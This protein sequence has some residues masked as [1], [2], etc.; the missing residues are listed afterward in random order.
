MLIKISF[1]EFEVVM[2]EEEAAK[3]MASIPDSENIFEISSVKV[4]TVDEAIGLWENLC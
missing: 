1:D 3:F 4:L 2:T